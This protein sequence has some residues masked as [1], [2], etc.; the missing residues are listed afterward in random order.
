MGFAP[1]GSRGY[2]IRA[3]GHAV[4]PYGKRDSD[5]Y[6]CQR[7]LLP[8]LVVSPRGQPEFPH[9]GEPPRWRETHPCRFSFRLQCHKEMAVSNANSFSPAELFSVSIHRY[10]PPPMPFLG[11]GHTNMPV[12]SRPTMTSRKQEWHV[13]CVNP[14]VSPGSFSASRC[15]HLTRRS[16]GGWTAMECPER[17]R[18]KKAAG[19]RGAIG[20]TSTNEAR[21]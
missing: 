19:V 16:D 7:S 12:C 6:V 17:R 11:S 1:T 5:V 2:M 9:H 3:G 8:E 14:D 18:S 15:A 13:L 10:L 20:E 21:V 4:C